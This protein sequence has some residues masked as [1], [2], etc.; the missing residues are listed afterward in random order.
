MTSEADKQDSE[1]CKRL[2]YIEEAD[3][4]VPGLSVRAEKDTRFETGFFAKWFRLIR[5]VGGGFL[6]VSSVPLRTELS[7]NVHYMV[8]YS[9]PH[10]DLQNKV[11]SSLGFNHDQREYA[12]QYCTRGF[13]IIRINRTGCAFPFPAMVEKPEQKDVLSRNA[14]EKL[15]E[16]SLR[17][18]LPDLYHL[19]DKLLNQPNLT[20]TESRYFDALVGNLF[21]NHTTL[22]DI[23]GLQTHDGQPARDGL[24][25]KS[26]ITLRKIPGK[27]GLY[28]EITELGIQTLLEN[29]SPY[30]GKGLFQHR[31]FC[32]H[33]AAHLR[34]LGFK[35]REEHLQA[36][37][38]C[39]K[40]GLVF[41]AEI[42]LTTQNCKDNTRRNAAHQMPT[43]LVVATKHDW[44]IASKN[45]KG[46]EQWASVHKFSD[47][48][49]CHNILELLPSQEVY[50]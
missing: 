38:V 20:P 16:K 37:L 25:R 5:S 8:C 33:T 14:L 12:L 49:K 13:P 35:V 6:L 42:S 45:I 29:K 22:M 1:R 40:D 2:I 9:Q 31:W 28:Y 19:Q 17:E 24:K 3:L 23:A 26:V 44:N 7:G 30:S 18:I 47:V 27:S 39:S 48:I 50:S 41:C 10:A 11:A 34:R 4:L 32:F 21:E 43:I 36:D 46:L 15:H